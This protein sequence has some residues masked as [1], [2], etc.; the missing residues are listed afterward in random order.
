MSLSKRSVYCYHFINR[1]VTQESMLRLPC[2]SCQIHRQQWTSDQAWE[3][4][5][6][7]HWDCGHSY[8]RGDR[9]KERGWDW[10][11]RGHTGLLSHNLCSWP[12]LT[13]SRGSSPFFWPAPAWQ[14]YLQ[15]GW[16][17]SHN[18]TQRWT[19]TA[20]ACGLSRP[21][22][23]ILGLTTSLL[24]TDRTNHGFLVDGRVWQEPVFTIR[25]I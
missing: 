21:W 24:A 1:W 4:T 8:P 9:N 22:E 17:L 23:G 10:L 2:L 6:G 7:S 14:L 11:K 13:L 25:L 16:R 3:K 18:F 19:W 20:R 5:W 12:T 15:G